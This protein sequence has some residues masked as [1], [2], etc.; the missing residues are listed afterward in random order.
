MRVDVDGTKTN[1]IPRVKGR[2]RLSPVLTAARRPRVVIETRSLLRSSLSSQATKSAANTTKS[3]I[4]Q[5]D[6]IHKRV[7][8][9]PKQLVGMNSFSNSSGISRTRIHLAQCSSPDGVTTANMSGTTA[10]H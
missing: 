10:M 7:R 4:G 3:T 2:H 9:F 8:Y 5:H 1:V 6:P